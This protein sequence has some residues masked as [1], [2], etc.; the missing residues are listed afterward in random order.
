MPLYD[1]KCSKC[2][3]T[4]ERIVK[5]DERWFCCDCGYLAN[6]VFPNTFNFKL[7]GKGWEKDGYSVKPEPKWKP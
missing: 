7:K 5:M 4:F 3:K 6:R 1:F 2:K